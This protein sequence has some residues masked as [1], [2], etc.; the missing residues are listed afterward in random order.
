MSKNRAIVWFRNDLRLHDNE[1]LTEAIR[2][3]D[4]VIPV[5]VFDERV[6]LG[7]TKFGF[8]KTGPF[9]AN[10]ILQ[11]VADL[12]RSFRERGAELYIRFGKP[13]EEIFNLAQESKANWVYCNRERTREEVL[14]QDA[15]EQKLWSTGRELRYCRGK[16][17]YYTSDLPFPVAQTP[18]IFTQFRKEVERF[19]PVRPPLP[20]PDPLKPARLQIAA[21]ELPLFAKLGH[22]SYTPDK[23]AVLSFEGGES[24]GLARL[25][26]YL[27]DTDLIK[28]YKETRNGL[29]GS[30]YS[31]KF[32]PWLAHG[33]LSPKQIYAEV[34]RYEAS[35]GNNES[36]YWVIFELLWRDFFRL[37]A[38]KY[39]DKIFLKGGILGKENGALRDDFKAFQRWK[40]GKTGKGIV[41][42]NMREIAS[43]GFM[44]N[45]GRQ[46]VASYLV[47]D[48]K[49]NW[50]L[51]AD[52]FESLLIDYD[53]ASNWGN[54]NYMAGVGN[55]PRENRYFN[56][57]TQAERYDPEG[58]Y[59]RFWL[60]GENDSVR[61]APAI[62]K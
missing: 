6:F 24:N 40:D 38:K 42:A 28:T 27:W 46:I 11:S 57:K 60:E 29:L 9:R 12:R 31:T 3:A 41:D 35:R 5:Y 15:L 58:K 30:D 17:L 16:M 48:L 23:R 33:C 44:S 22:S 61:S 19:I 47:N 55:D 62:S 45:R 1:A 59:V 13:E 7:K 8:S 37:M 49:V 50:Q 36:T 18:D 4:E 26:Y 54:W 2:N 21:G 25:Q 34:R 32:S 51:G 43:T 39:G 10:F 53:P 20:V 52:Y 56:P 14:V